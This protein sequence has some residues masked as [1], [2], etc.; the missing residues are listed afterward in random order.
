[1]KVTCELGIGNDQDH[2]NTSILI[3]GYPFEDSGFIHLVVDG[4]TYEV[5]PWELVEAVGRVRSG[6]AMTLTRNDRD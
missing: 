2:P 1:M 3:E 4:K 5:K 6:I